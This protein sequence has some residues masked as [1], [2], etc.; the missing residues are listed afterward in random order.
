MFTTLF[1]A[2]G[3]VTEGAVSFG[4]Q[5]PRAVLAILAAAIGAVVGWTVVGLAL[6]VNPFRGI[7][8]LLFVAA[9]PAAAMLQGRDPDLATRLTVSIFVA[10]IGMLAF[11][12]IFDLV[13]FGPA[14]ASLRSTV[15]GLFG[16]ISLVVVFLGHRRF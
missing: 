2:L 11:R 4:A 16:L 3:Q 1:R 14:E 13:G 15:T 12:V 8:I 10:V 6:L 5:N 7:W 9:L